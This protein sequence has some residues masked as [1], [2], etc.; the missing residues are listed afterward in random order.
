MLPEDSAV[1]IVTYLYYYNGG[2][3]AAGDIDG[4]GLVDLYFT[5]NLGSN[6]LYRNLGNFQFE[7]VTARAG[8]ADSVGWKSG[9]TMADVNGDGRLDIYVSGVDYLGM[10]GRNVLYINNG[11]GTFTD[12]TDEYGLAFSGYST[13]AAF[14]DYDGDG[15]LD[16]YLLNS[17]TFAELRARKSPSRTERN[18]R[19]G[20]R[21]YRNDRG[22]FVDVSAS[23]HIYG[24]V[25]GFG[26]GVAIS[27]LNLDGCPDIYIANDFPENDF[28]YLN[29]CNGTFTE[30]IAQATGHTSRFSMGADAADFNNDGRP[31]IAVVDMLPDSERI[32]KTA[33]TAESYSL[34]NQ[35]L[36]LDYHYQYAR[37]TLQLNR[38]V[39]DGK[40]RFSEIGLL[41]GI[42]ATDWSWAPL[43][44]DYDNDGRKDLFVTT[45]IYRRPNDLDYIASFDS[46]PTG[47]EPPAARLIAKMPHVPQP[48][49]AFHNNGDLTFTN[50]AAQWGL[51]AAGFSNGAAYV[52]LDN[53]G[54][55]DL[56]VNNL[57]APATVYRN[58]ARDLD[59]AGHHFLTVTLRGSGANTGG[60][61]A[62]VMIAAG[63]SHQLVEVMPTR[64][65]ESAVDPRAHFGLGT[66]SRVDSLTVIWPD[67]RYQLLANVPADQIITVSQS[68]AHTQ[69]PSRPT[70]HRPRFSDVTDRLPI[71]YK[72]ADNTFFDF[73]REPLMLHLL[74]TEGPA[75]A[76]G[77]VN[78]D[79]VDDIYA[80]GAKWQA[81]ELFL[82]GRE[83]RFKA[84]AEPAFRADS[85]HE[86]VDAAFF[87]ADGDGDLDLYVVS[88]GNEFWE[89]EPLHDR[90]YLNDGRGNFSRAA[91]P[92]FAHNGSCVALGGD[93]LFVGSRVV[94]RRYGVTPRSYLLEN[95]G[96]GHFRD[97]TATIA[98]GLDSVGMVTAASWV[99]YDGD[100]KL[101]LIVVGEWMPVRA[102]HQENGRFVDRTEQSGFAH[103]NGWWTSVQAADLNADGHPDLI[104][105]N[106]G[107]NSLLRASRAEPAQLYVGDFFHTG[108]LA[109]ILTSYWHG[110]SYPFA[111]RDELLQIMPSLRSRYPTYASFGASR[112]QDIIPRQELK[113]ARV[114]EADTF[115]SAIA[116]NRGDGTFELRELPAEAQFAPIYASLVEDFDGDGNTDLIVA[117]N[118]YGVT[119]AEGRYD[120]SYGLF[121]HGDGRGGFAAVGM[122]QS[123]LAIDGQARHL[124]LLKRANGDQVI[125]VAKNSDRLQ[126]IR[127][128]Q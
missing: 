52:D 41:A 104:L 66:S 63:G 125:V 103:T 12:R 28:L 46:V 84:V 75:L 91:L 71:S 121:L 23:A 14:F 76:V 64:G 124:A 92:D 29:N 77:D 74:S 2:G 80:G 8:V 15:D 102:F 98:P 32:L 90:L 16:M 122:E 50:L 118:F 48:N 117:G 59:S 53:D 19:A 88:G 115:A 114:L 60:V 110:V 85:L 42:A 10:K 39:T 97:V 13:Q 68:D 38:G 31:D 21:L 72:H 127:S 126:L 55:L 45:G 62:K 26:L 108:T 67:R 35:K 9:V 83:G 73:G 37:N 106:F 30:S 25:E 78:G 49:Y 33:A 87:D 89:G 61:G 123:G 94:A 65:F 24:G 107:L 44:A 120:A 3:V 40:L 69:P 105:G 20:D 82:Q 34:F 5:S 7:D 4:D 99:D 79:G 57:N 111:G 11:D 22:H 70:A 101:D 100:G 6:R 128:V 17:S 1:N 95:D 93:F 18:A 116:L 27:D 86:D 119:P 113:K 58:R 36:A 112:I 54:A 43:F 81:G 47:V 96:H 56:V 51:N 109:Q